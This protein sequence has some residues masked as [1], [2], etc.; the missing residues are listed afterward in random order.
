MNQDFNNNNIAGITDNEDIYK[1]IEEQEKLQAEIQELERI[2]KTKMSR[3][4]IQ[5]YGALKLT[6]PEKAIKAIALIA[7]AVKAG[8]KENISDEEFKQILKRLE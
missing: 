6:H 5:R 7:H 8:L 3:E 2:A 1:E 4:A